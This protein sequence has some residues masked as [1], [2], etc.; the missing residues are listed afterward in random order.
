MQPKILTFN[1]VSP[2][3][4]FSRKQ[5]SLSKKNVLLCDT[6]LAVTPLDLQVWILIKTRILFEHTIGIHGTFKHS[7]SFFIYKGTHTKTVWEC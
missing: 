5:F 7:Y 2:I 4:S 1:L 6:D 3:I